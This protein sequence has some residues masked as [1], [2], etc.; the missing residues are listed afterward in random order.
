METGAEC[1]RSEVAAE[2][3]IPNAVSVRGL[4]VARLDASELLTEAC[5]RLGIDLANLV[6]AT[7]L[8]ASPEI[9][10]AL[11]GASDAPAWYPKTQRAGAGQKRGTF[12]GEVRLDDNTYANVAIK[13]ALGLSPRNVVGFE[14]CHVWPGTT[15]DPRYHTCIA[16]L[17]L[18]PRSLASLS[19]HDATVQRAI[20]YR[21]FELYAWS[22]EG[23]PLPEKPPGYPLEWRQPAAVTPGIREALRRRHRS[24]GQ[25]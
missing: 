9:H 20:Q 16:N 24:V 21:S 4:G 12:V 10:A 3:A 7:G 13:R 17:I 15:Y 18:L 23:V 25:P 19:D 5:A 11:A 2:R 14:V 6:A 22:P 8:W 1:E